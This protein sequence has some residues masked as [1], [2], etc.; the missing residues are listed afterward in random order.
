MAPNRRGSKVAAIKN[1][2]AIT[3]FNQKIEY[4]S[5]DC[6]LNQSFH[7]LILVTICHLEVPNTGASPVG[8]GAAPDGAGEGF[9]F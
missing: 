1:H 7:A 8:E 9:C 6:F 4:K 3:F 5:R 2:R